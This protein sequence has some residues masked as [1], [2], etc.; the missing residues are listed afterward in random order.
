MQSVY[1]QI[2]CSTLAGLDYLVIQLLLHLSD[3]FLNACRMYTS[4]CHKLM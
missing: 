1:S 4:V 3:N 2:D